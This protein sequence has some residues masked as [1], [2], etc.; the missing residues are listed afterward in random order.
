MK[1]EKKREEKVNVFM[2]KRRKMN[3][4]NWC[5]PASLK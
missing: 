3:I 5:L 2:G 4:N 1:R